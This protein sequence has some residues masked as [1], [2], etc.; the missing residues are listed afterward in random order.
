MGLRLHATSLIEVNKLH[1]L[2]AEYSEEPS[3]AQCSIILE[4]LDELTAKAY[5]NGYLD[6]I[7]GSSEDQD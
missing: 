7:L 3:S 2:V 4:L 6:G 5:D 1:D